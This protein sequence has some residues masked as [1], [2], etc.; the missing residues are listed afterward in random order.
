M[1]LTR[2]GYGGHVLAR[3]MSVERVEA[4]VA[5]GVAT[6]PMSAH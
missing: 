1:T 5:E 6:V 4:L 2:N 3:E